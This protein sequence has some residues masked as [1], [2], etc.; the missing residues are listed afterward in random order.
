M[1][2]EEEGN[3]FKTPTKQPIPAS[4]PESVLRRQISDVFADKSLSASQK[5]ARVNQLRGMA[6]KK[7][8]KEKKKKILLFLA[9]F[10]PLSRPLKNRPKQLSPTSR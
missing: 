2:E 3:A 7:E 10:L 6:V 8:K 5:F 9:D 4:N 1:E